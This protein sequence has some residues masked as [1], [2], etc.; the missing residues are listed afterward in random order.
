MNNEEIINGET[1]EEFCM[2]VAKVQREANK[3]LL[4][5]GVKP[6]FNSIEEARQYYHSISFKEWENNM[7]ANH[8][9]G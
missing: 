2:R 3:I 9:M 8:N 5:E 1:F 4:K 6:Q 7:F